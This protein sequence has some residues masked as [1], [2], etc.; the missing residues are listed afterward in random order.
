[1]TGAE[2]VGTGESGPLGCRGHL[3]RSWSSTRS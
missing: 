1:L 3:A 2:I